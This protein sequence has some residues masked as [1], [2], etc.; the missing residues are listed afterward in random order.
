MR[1]KQILSSDGWIDSEVTVEGLLEELFEHLEMHD[2][3]PV[4]EVSIDGM[5][6]LGVIENEEVVR[7]LLTLKELLNDYQ[8][9]D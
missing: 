2:G 4:V 6:A 9:I 7:I 8:E 5:P 1:S 3:L